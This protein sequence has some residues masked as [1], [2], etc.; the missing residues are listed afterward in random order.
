MMK[1]LSRRL[2][3][4]AL[5][6]VVALS[7]S[8][9]CPSSSSSGRRAVVL[10][11]DINR[12]ILMSDSAGRRSIRGVVSYLLAELCWGRVRRAA[13][14]EG[15]GGGGG[16]QQQHWEPISV[17]GQLTPG[18]T[19]PED[20][21]VTYKDWVD[22]QFPYLRSG[23]DVVPADMAG[24][25][26][27]IIAYNLAMK[28]ERSR[29]QATFTDLGQ[30]GERYRS[31]LEKLLKQ[32]SFQPGSAAAAHAATLAAELSATKESKDLAATWASG[33]YFL[34][35]SFLRL[36]LHIDAHEELRSRVF[37]VFRTFGADLLEVE[38]ELR[39]LSEGRHPLFLPTTTGA[40]Q[41]LGKDFTLSYPSSY[42]AFF[43][44]GYGQNDVSLAVNTISKPPSGCPDVAAFYDEERKREEEKEGSPSPREDI[45]IYRGYDK[46]FQAF[47]RRFAEIGR[48]TLGLRD[49]WEWWH[50]HGESDDTGKLLL[51]GG[52]ATDHDDDGAAKIRTSKTSAAEKGGGEEEK[53][54]E[55]EGLCEWPQ[56]DQAHHV[57]IDDHV[58]HHHAHIVDVRTLPD[59]KPMPFDAASAAQHVFRSE[60]Y[61]AV[62]DP[63][64][65]V[66][67]VESILAHL[68]GG[69]GE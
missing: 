19:P 15:G 61:L 23:R 68:D 46:S 59:G 8:Q 57:F 25:H 32:M 1:L 43:R 28:R 66:R 41:R 34:L 39:I 37:L 58:E 36:L 67:R 7:G 55:K 42:G 62:Q 13:R 44:D 14:D 11:F 49:Y 63:D 40:S 6:L 30:P 26:D 21:A 45:T 5:L 29:R 24:V 27:S 33:R 20:G 38:Q 31:D 47:T 56:V 64:Y 53:E 3:Y 4:T 17:S 2:L 54:V 22:A 18:S 50:A 65:F 52:D 60:P 12:T 9:D 69:G 16:G 51:V 10:H 35:P 48:R